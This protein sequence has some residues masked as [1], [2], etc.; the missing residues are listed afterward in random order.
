MNSD[1][2]KLRRF[3]MQLFQAGY[4]ERSR[5][6]SRPANGAA[7]CHPLDLER[8]APSNKRMQRTVGHASKLAC[9]PAADPQHR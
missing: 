5:D 2:E 3:A 9:P 6:A 1:L 7:D 8:F 4:A